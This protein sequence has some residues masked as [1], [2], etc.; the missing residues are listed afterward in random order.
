MVQ[1]SRQVDDETNPAEAIPEP[2]WRRI[3]KAATRRPLTRDAIVETALRILDHDGVD[4]V[5]M[6]AVAEELGTGPA[7][8]YWHVADKDELL[9]LV[10]DRIVGEVELPVSK[11][12]WQEQLKEFARSIRSV[13]S[14]H[15]DVARITLARIPTGPNAMV[16]MDWMLG[17]MRS[18]GLPGRVIALGSDAALLYVNAFC[19]EESI[20]FRAAGSSG[21]EALELL[22]NYFASLPPDRFPNFTALSPDMTGADFD[23]RFEFG[24]DMVLGGIE[25]MARPKRSTARRVER[26]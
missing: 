3:R 26:S 14:S 15:R 22:E 6:R 7:S 24:L 11:G 2:P 8:L 9:D 18:A 13:Y 23:E 19:Y 20:P 12:P 1:C 16:R 4:A 5:S 25:A 21:T 10:F 17:V